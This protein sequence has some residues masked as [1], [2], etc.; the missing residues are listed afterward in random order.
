SRAEETVAIAALTQA[1]VAKLTR[2]FEANLGIR[3]YPRALI[4]ENKFRALRSGLDGKM[5]DFGLRAEAPTR[6]LIHEVLDFGDDVVDELGSRPEMQYLRAWAGGG[7][8]GADRQLRV[9]AE[10]GDLRAVVDHLVGETK[11]GL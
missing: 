4:M 9:F 10:T 7:D 6:A 11:Q 3:A 8:T 5:I 1:L 2:L